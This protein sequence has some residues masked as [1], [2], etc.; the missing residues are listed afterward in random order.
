M[1]RV[2]TASSSTTLRGAVDGEEAGAFLSWADCMCS[3]RSQTV[4]VT[5][6]QPAQRQIPRD[7]QDVLGTPLCVRCTFPPCGSLSLG[8]FLVVG[9]GRF[10]SDEAA[11][12]AL[13]RLYSAFSRIWRRS[14]HSITARRS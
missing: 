3:A 5:A 11:C 1:E 6:P 12:T 7:T 14:S 9:F 8:F 2:Y 4:R 13:S 10:L